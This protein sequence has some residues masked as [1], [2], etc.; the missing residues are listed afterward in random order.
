MSGSLSQ[1]AAARILDV[2]ERTLGRW[3]DAGRLERRDDGIDPSSLV[4]L[5]VA[6]VHDRLVGDADDVRRAWTALA[7]HPVVIVEGEGGTTILDD[8]ARTFAHATPVDLRG[9]HEAWQV[10]LAVASAIAAPVR[11]ELVSALVETFRQRVPTLLLLD[12]R[13][14]SA[15]AL[16]ECLATWRTSRVKALVL[17]DDPKAWRE[18]P[19][20]RVRDR[21]RAPPIAESPEVADLLDAL[22]L[23]TS[24]A[25][26]L[27]L[28]ELLG[29]SDVEVALRLR[30]E[31]AR[32]VVRSSRGHDGAPRHRLTSDRRTDRV[33]LDGQSSDTRSSDGQS[34]SQNAERRDAARYRSRHA[35]LRARWARRATAAEILARWA[36]LNEIVRG[37]E[38]PRLRLRLAARCAWASERVLPAKAVDGMLAAALDAIDEEDPRLGRLRALVACARASVHTKR[39]EIDDAHQYVEAAIRIADATHDPRWM[40]SA[41]LRRAEL[42]L[43]LHRVGPRTL[44]DFEEAAARGAL[45]RDRISAWILLGNAAIGPGRLADAEVAYTHAL[46][47][48]RR[49]AAERERYVALGNLALVAML[50]GRPERAVAMLPQVLS[51]HD[52][53]G[54]RLSSVYV[55]LNLAIARV[56]LGTH[57]DAIPALRDLLGRIG[58]AGQRAARPAALLTLGFARLDRIESISARRT[59]EAGLRIASEG[60][61]DEGCLRMGLAFA[62]ASEPARAA[63]EMQRARA[64]LERAAHRYARV[65]EAWEAAFLGLAPVSSTDASSRDAEAI[66]LAATFARG[67]AEPQELERALEARSVLVRCAARVAMARVRTSTL[68]VAPDGSTFVRDGQRVSLGA[69]RIPRRLLAALHAAGERGCSLQEL[70]EAGWPEERLPLE[71]VRHRVHA[72]LGALRRVGL[73]GR[74]VIDVDGRHRLR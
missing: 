51:A 59:F 52:A 31:A 54:D 26:T 17:V 29:V 44:A 4:Q 65:A 35:R 60:S 13:T 56:D 57:A 30:E 9:C 10:A 53:D 47:A 19:T 63:I 41:R 7:S 70:Y 64:C 27:E 25:T 5:A 2:S 28:A 39:G 69:K 58:R 16:Q 62:C 71:R 55:A 36:E 32:S 3:L 40:A 42:E 66:A 15:P 37:A 18:C 12:T 74:L 34:A 8:V 49:V 50:D 72:A 73:D 61:F 22:S 21:E 68:W 20:L 6:R 23:C 45:A 33:V 67:T 14:S 38:N 24:G 46:V 43:R 1:R 48:T 11:R